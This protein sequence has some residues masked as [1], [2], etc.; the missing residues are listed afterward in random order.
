MRDARAYIDAGR[1]DPLDDQQRGEHPYDFVSL[2]SQ[3]TLHPGTGHDRLPSN[4]LSGSLRLV[5]AL[6]T[7]LHIGSGVFATAGECGLGEA[8]PATPVRGIVRSSGQPVVP[9]SSWK[10]AI[11]TRFEAITRSRLALVDAG[12]KEPASKVPAALKDAKDPRRQLPVRITDPRVTGTLAPLRSV[13]GLHEMSPAEALFGG[14]GYRGRIHPNDGVLDG[15]PA[16]VPLR[17]P[18]QESPMMHRLGIPGSVDRQGGTIFLGKVEG[19]KFYYDGRLLES[20]QPG[21]R[22]ELIDHV[23][24]GSTLTLDVGLTSVDRAELGALLI[25]AG[26]GEDVGIVR[27]GGFKNAGLGKVRLVEATSRLVPNGR[28]A[29]VYKANT[30]EAADLTQAVATARERLVDTTALDQLHTVTSR[31]RP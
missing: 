3:A 26:M 18:P 8:A 29:R 31:K 24:A 21:D 6:E 2:P 7:P 23:P 12:C 22:Y 10:G 4:R 25:A 14:L 28:R 1:S 20:G 30:A 16:A 5:Y 27:L 13:N 19:R 17:V 15:P 9:G 11:R